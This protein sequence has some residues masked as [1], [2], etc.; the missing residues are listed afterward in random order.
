MS[1]FVE[2][3][4][5]ADRGF[6]SGPLKNG[7]LLSTQSVLIPVRVGPVYCNKRRCPFTPEDSPV[8]VHFGDGGGYENRLAQAD[9]TH[10]IDLRIKLA[11]RCRQSVTYPLADS[12][13]R[14]CK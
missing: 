7:R 9:P 8:A 3:R 10:R 5:K 6:K 4:R 12:P 11:Y 14:L 1:V 2:R 13:R